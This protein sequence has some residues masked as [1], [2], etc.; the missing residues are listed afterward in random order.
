VS[1][2]ELVLDQVNTV[3]SLIFTVPELGFL[4]RTNC[5]LGD[6]LPS[7]TLGETKI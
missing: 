5:L 4:D 7:T 2:F 6:P 1:I 3:K